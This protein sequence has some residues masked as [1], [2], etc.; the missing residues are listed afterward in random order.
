MGRAIRVNSGRVTNPG[1]TFTALTPNTGDRFAIDNF[2][3]ASSAYLVGVW[4]QA[5]TAGAIRIRSP[6]LHDASQAIRLVDGAQT[7]RLLLPLGARQSVY[8]G[9]TL[10]VEMTGGAAETDVGAFLLYYE[11][12][13]GIEARLAYARDVLPAIQNIVVEEVTA[14]PSST[15]GDYGA[16]VSIVS[17]YDVLK[18]NTDYALL[19]YLVDA[20]AAV[21]AIQG[22]DT[23]NL[24]IGGPGAP[25]FYDTRRYFLMLSEA[26]DMPC[27]PI[28]NANNRGATLVQIA[29]TATTGNVVVS[30]I[31]AELS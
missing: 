25:D 18:A 10:T 1:T 22:P 13:P 4:A 20:A 27:V 5:G 7:P 17:T 6:R 11:N 30:L 19:G 24:R 2:D 9:D 16:S 21:V 28:I 14:A 23:G 31:L 15:A 8:P 3:V 29:R 26:L 12:L